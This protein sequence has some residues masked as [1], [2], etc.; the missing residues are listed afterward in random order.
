MHVR[1]HVCTQALFKRFGGGATHNRPAISYRMFM[2][3]M[4]EILMLMENEDDGACS[5]Q[6]MLAGHP[7]PVWTRVVGTCADARVQTCA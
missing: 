7:G 4:H 6:H 3:G 2:A 5:V 1:T